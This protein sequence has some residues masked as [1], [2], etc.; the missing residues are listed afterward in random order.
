MSLWLH[1]ITPCFEVMPFFQTPHPPTPGKK[2]SHMSDLISDDLLAIGFKRRRSHGD[3][4]SGPKP[5]RP[6]NPQNYNHPQARVQVSGKTVLKNHGWKPQRNN[7]RNIS[8][9]FFLGKKKI[10]V[11]T[12]SCLSHQSRRSLRWTKTSRK[13]KRK[14]FSKT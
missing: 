14:L 10:D 1:W 2:V 11:E 12:L 6:L 8:L 5:C 4:T 9:P 13:K 7:G 3:R